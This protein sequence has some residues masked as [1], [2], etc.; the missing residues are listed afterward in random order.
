MV[1]V[2]GKLA[3]LEAITPGW[4]HLVRAGKLMVRSLEAI[5]LKDSKGTL[6]ILSVKRKIL[7]IPMCFIPNLAYM[8]HTFLS[9]A[10]M[11]FT[12]EMSDKQA[13]PKMS[14]SLNFLLCY[15]TCFS[16]FSH[17]SKWN[18]HVLSCTILCNILSLSFFTLHNSFHIS[19]TEKFMK[20]L[21][22]LSY[23]YPL[24][25]IFT[26]PILSRLPTSFSLTSI[27]LLMK[28][29]NFAPLAPVCS[30]MAVEVNF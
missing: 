27:I 1:Q 9:N 28:P 25:S 23:S 22:F 3:H 2:I 14:Q 11:T 30:Y 7:L 29:P 13:K 16:C 15:S 26:V 20:F 8:F 17:L 5:Q 12:T 18:H 10:S 4:A 19:H 21:I 6:E 24:L